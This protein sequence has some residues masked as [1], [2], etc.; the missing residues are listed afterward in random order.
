MFEEYYEIF[1]CQTRYTRQEETTDN[2]PE[3][4]IF[5]GNRAYNPTKTSIICGVLLTLSMVLK[6]YYY[7]E[8]GIFEYYG[9]KL[10]VVLFN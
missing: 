8:L 1:L 6:W 10:V 2:T 5:A 9:Y 3:Y 7:F 4:V